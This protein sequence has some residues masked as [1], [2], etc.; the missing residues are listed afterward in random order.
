MTRDPTSVAI[1]SLALD[2]LQ[3]ME[4]H[5]PRPIQLLPVVDKSGCPVGMI[6]VHTLV[7]AGLTSDRES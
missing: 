5:E 1:D 3:M 6:H 4:E 7:R 2:A